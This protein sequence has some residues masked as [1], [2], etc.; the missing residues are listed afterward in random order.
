MAKDKKYPTNQERI[1]KQK[2]LLITQIKKTPVIEIACQKVGVG[3]T[4]F[5]RWRRDDADFET[6]C[7]EAL[8]TGVDLINDLAESKLIGQIQDSNFPAIRFWLQ[9]HHKSYKAKLEISADT[10]K[11]LTSEEQETMQ[12]AYERLGLIQ[13][14]NLIE[15]YEQSDSGSE[16]TQPDPHQQNGQTR[17]GDEV[18]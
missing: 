4:T 12:Q 17:P 7:V 10:K 13:Q 14:N 2:D 9:S 11:E 1:Q 18:A 3:R 6:A 15:P 8:G 16:D 5:Y